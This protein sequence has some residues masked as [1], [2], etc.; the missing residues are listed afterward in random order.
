MQTKKFK[1][2]I[3]LNWKQNNM[4]VVKRKPTDVGPFELPLE[5]EVNVQLPEKQ[6]KKLSA[7]IEISETKVSEMVAHQV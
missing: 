4:R 2:Y 5:L 1:S 6:I 3:I 7:D